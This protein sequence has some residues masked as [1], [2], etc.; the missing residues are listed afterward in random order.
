MSKKVLVF[1]SSG[2]LASALR[3][4][5]TTGEHVMRFVGRS[6]VDITNEAG[7]VGLASWKPDVIVNAAAYTAV[8][9]AEAE[10]ARANAVNVDGVANLVTL[11]QTVEAPLIHVSTDYVFDGL[12]LDRDRWYAEE[13]RTNPL[14]VYGASKLEGEILALQSD[15]GTVLRTSFVYSATGGN[16]VKTILRLAGQDLPL[17]VVDDQRGCPTSAFQL[18]EV[19]NRVIETDVAVPGLFHA[20]SVAGASWWEFATH[21]LELAGIDKEIE[22]IPTSEF[23]LPAKRPEDA[24][25]SS[26]KLADQYGIEIADWREG[27]V[28]VVRELCNE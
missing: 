20:A 18:A 27:L 10:A 28:P 15:R 6:E 22:P 16:F 11:G 9:A 25:M 2:Q 12:R 19:V 5:V 21:I 4:T 14:N 13:D 3:N 1:G 23:P 7:V 24:R 26:A 8:D 17:R